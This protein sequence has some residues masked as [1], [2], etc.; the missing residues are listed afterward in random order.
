MGLASDIRRKIEKKQQLL[1]ELEANKDELEM[2]IREALAAI[3]AYQEV[4]KLTPADADGADK[5]EPNLRAGS[6]PA[7][8]R[9]ALQKH[10]AAMHV[11]KLLEAMSKPGTQEN[12]IALSSSLASYAKDKKIFTKPNANTFGLLE[13]DAAKET[14]DDLVSDQTTVDEAVDRVAKASK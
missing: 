7:L 5:G 14:V 8:A 10:G 9:A 13:W 12:R 4:L 6:L 3:Q 1:F 11:A 2:Q